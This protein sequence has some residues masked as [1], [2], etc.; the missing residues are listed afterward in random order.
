VHI[1]SNEL[2]ELTST[3]SAAKWNTV[4]GK[5]KRDRDG[6]Y[7]PNWYIVVIKSGLMHRVS[8]SWDK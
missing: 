6:K 3:K 8:S 7:P 1:T 5:I 2:L 4:C